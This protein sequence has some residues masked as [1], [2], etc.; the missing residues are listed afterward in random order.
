MKP[1]NSDMKNAVW[2]NVKGFG[3]WEHVGGKAQLGGM[4]GQKLHKGV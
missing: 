1:L 3:R 2:S 4:Y